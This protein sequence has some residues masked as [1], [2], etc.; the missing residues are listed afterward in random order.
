MR[1]KDRVRHY[2]KAH[3]SATVREIQQ[4]LNIS[5]PS[6]VQYHLTSDAKADS[7]KLLREALD[8]C[9]TQLAHC[10]GPDTEAGRMAQEALDAT[11]I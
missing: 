5:S 8:A 11:A 6:V 9:A 10:L 4:A 1:T 2:R 3:P 7:V